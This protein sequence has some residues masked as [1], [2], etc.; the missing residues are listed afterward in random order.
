MFSGEVCFLLSRERYMNRRLLVRWKRLYCSGVD[1]RETERAIF[2]F[3]F[4]L[5]YLL[6]IVLVRQVILF[7]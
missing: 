5:L 6:I 2:R 4:S 1:G 7:P 3:Y